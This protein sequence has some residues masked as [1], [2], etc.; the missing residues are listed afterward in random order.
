[1][2][3]T[4]FHDD[5]SR[6]KKQSELSTFAGRYQLNTPGPGANLPYFADPQVRLEK[7]GANTMT[8]TVNLESDLFGLSRKLNRDLIDENSYKKH[9]APTSSN[10]YNNAPEF[11][12]ESRASHP[13]WMYRDL[14]HKRWEKPWLNPLANLEKGFHS[15]I[16]TRI[17][18]KDN[19]VP[20]I[21]ILPGNSDF[22]LSGKSLCLGGKNGGSECSQIH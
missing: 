17:L 8:N 13:A 12:E 2:A 11:V 15:N 3:F 14:E 16:Q 4:R 1:M 21:P 22:Y 19:F 6:I 9:A 7:W 18:E 10:S 20:T 5:P